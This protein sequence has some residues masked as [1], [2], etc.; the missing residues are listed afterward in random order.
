MS[1]SSDIKS[2]ILS[3]VGKEKRECCIKAET[4]GELLTS[5]KLKSSLEEEYKDYF[6]IGNLKECCIKAV[7]KG[8]FLSSG[9][10]VSPDSDYHF[11]LT[12]KNKAC[13]EY[14]LNLL[15]VLEFTP[16]MLKRKNA[17]SYIIYIK[18]SEQ[19]SLFLSMIEASNA[20][21]KF[22]NIRVERD[23]K[24]NINRN[25]NCETANLSKTIETSVKQLSAIE[26]IKRE[27]LY[28]SLNDKLKYTASL[29][30]KY[31]EESLD[32]IASKTSGK[33]KVTKSG[34]KHRLDKLVKIASQIEENK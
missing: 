10:I 3:K 27:G 2:E 4:F 26:K 32:Y 7:L 5:A 1:F 18:D 19:I 30:E 23:L 16:K 11:E 15:S 13:A 20:L 8:V 29:R 31:K 6:D 22:E 33:N 9:C 14:I 24:N 25:I 17:G 12:F 34:L 28:D 21:F